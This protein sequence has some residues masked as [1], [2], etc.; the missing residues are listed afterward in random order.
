MKTFSLKYGKTKQTFELPDSWDS[1]VLNYR[2]PEPL[3]PEEALLSSLKDPIDTKPLDIW[4]KDFK[5]ILIICPD[6]T[7]YSG[8]DYLLPVIY[9]KYLKEKDLEIIFALGNHRKQSDEEK[10][11]IISEG[12]FKAVHSFDHDCFNRDELSFFGRTS[13]GLDVLLN[14]VLVET[15]GAIVT[16]SI[17]F[18][19]LAG[20][21]GGRKS[22]FPGIAG[23]ETI[24]GIHSKVFNPDRPGKHEKAKS[25]ILKGNPMHEEIMEGIA[26]I[27]TPMFLINTVI[28][29]KKELLNIFTGDLKTAH[30]QGCSWYLKHFGVRVQ[31]KADIVI[32]SSGGFPK[33]INFIQTHKAIEH[34]L[35]AVKKDG[36]MIVVGRCEDGL[37]NADFLRWFAYP[38]I[39]DME[40]HVRTSDKVYAQTAYATRLKAQYCKII[41]ISD[42]E[43]DV[44]K[45]MGIAHAKTVEEALSLIK[46]NKEPLCY[47]I[48]NG[49]NMLVQ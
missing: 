1:R 49:S 11:G 36:Y 42:L 15:D 8:I 30:E 4:L 28:D 10:A 2:E 13:S 25:G 38:T 21:G 31:E 18:H 40:P 35:N 43:E 32:V 12:I 3:H 39:E 5:K 17:N 46:V 19:Y 9:E 20:F 47:I 26:L 48:P 33:D 29:D 6:V 34:A 41:L 37:G 27:K 24:L 22:I 44:V 16:G 7:R 14:R 23:Y 45:K